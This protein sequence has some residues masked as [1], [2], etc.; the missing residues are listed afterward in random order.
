MLEKSISI[1]GPTA[2]LGKDASA[3]LS[4]RA[5]SSSFPPIFLNCAGTSSSCA[6][7]DRN[8]PLSAVGGY[9]LP[10]YEECDDDGH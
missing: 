2:E 9:P 6:A 7:T 10:C 5:S 8:S 3:D 1:Y 4:T